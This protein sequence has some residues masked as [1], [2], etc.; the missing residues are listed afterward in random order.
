MRS[1]CRGLRHR[2]VPANGKTTHEL[3]DF[4]ANAMRTLLVAMR[5]QNIVAAQEKVTAARAAVDAAQRHLE[6]VERAYEE[7]L[8]LVAASDS[9]HRAVHELEL[10]TEV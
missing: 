4:A 7:A 8:A 3:H 1:R 5:H 9:T 2:A 10:D 6:E